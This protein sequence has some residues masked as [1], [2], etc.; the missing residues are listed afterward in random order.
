[1]DDTTAAECA[2]C[3][4][5][6]TGPYC[7]QC[8][9][10]VID[11]EAQTVRHLVA[12]TLADEVAH[13]DGKFW[14]TLRGLVCRPGFLSEEYCA[15][16][17]RPYIKP[18]RLLITSII[19]YALLTQ[20][21]LLVTLMIGPVA[22]SVAPVAVP[23][24]LSVADTVTRIDRFNLLAPVLAAKERSTD[25]TSEAARQR[26]HSRLNQFAQPLSFA[27]VV[28][29]GLVLY[30]LFRR[31]RG[32]LVEH[33]VFSMHVV[34]FVL[35]SSLTLVP[36]VRIVDTSHALGL[37]IMLAVTIWQFAYLSIALRRFYFTDGSLGRRRTLAI[38]MAFLVY[39][40]NSAFITIIQLLGGAIALRSI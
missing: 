33:M 4:T 3:R 1:M 13:L 12:H 14:R 5:P 6:L 30:L 18:V 2:S 21:G 24:G 11:S 31:K 35:L 38:A 9:E 23:V 7:A 20:G 28:L 25:T 19:T 40:L 8:G 26:F 27:N 36:A 10:K 22:L 16:R 32:L 29:L 39:I 34:S 17:R 15:G 37:A